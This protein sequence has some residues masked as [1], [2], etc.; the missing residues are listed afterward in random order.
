MSISKT[1]SA[2]LGLSIGAMCAAMPAVAETLKYGA[3]G[4]MSS[5]S[6]SATSAKAAVG[7]GSRAKASVSRGTSSKAK[8]SSTRKRSRR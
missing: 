2:I 5:V 1:R 3:G 4:Y 8:F 6:S 7:G